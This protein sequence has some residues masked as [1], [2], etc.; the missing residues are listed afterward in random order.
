MHYSPV[1]PCGRGLLNLKYTDECVA[2]RLVGHGI[3]K[4]LSYDEQER[5]STRRD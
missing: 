4:Q 1:V 5:S 3:E 2:L